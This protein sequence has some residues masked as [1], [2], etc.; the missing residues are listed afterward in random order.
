MKVDMVA[1]ADPAQL[2][3]ECFDQAAKIG[4]PDVLHIPRDKPIR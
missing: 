3:L 2:E 1:A 4:E